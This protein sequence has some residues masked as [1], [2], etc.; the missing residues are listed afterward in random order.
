MKHRRRKLFSIPY[1]ALLSLSIIF[2][3]VFNSSLTGEFSIMSQGTI[4]YGWLRAEGK[5]LVDDEGHIVIL[6]GANFMGYG[7]GNWKRHTLEDYERMKSWGFN[8][9]R[10]P[11]GW[12]YMEPKPGF[13]NESYFA[14]I[15][16]DIT[17]AKQ[18]GLYVVINVAHLRWSPYFTFAGGK[19]NGLPIWMVNG[20]PDSLDGM[21]EA[22]TDFWLGKASNG[23]EPTTDNPSMQDRFVAMWK[24]LAARYRNETTIAAYDLF[25]EPLRG[26]LSDREAAKYIYPFYEKV[27]SG[28][29]QVDKNH[30]I[31]YQPSPGGYGIRY[32]RL[33]N[34]SNVMF[35]FHFYYFDG[36][37][38]KVNPPYSGNYE[39]LE[40]TF[41]TMRWELPLGNPIS[42]WNIP[43][44][45]GGFGSG[46]ETWARDTVKIFGKYELGWAWWAYYRSD[47]NPRALLYLNGSERLYLTQY[48][49]QT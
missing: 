34:Q 41:L 7:M 38:D 33:L 12:N 45:V 21:K 27:I 31:I 39:E 20:Y 3:G 29:R 42:N 24:Y 25:D 35:D 46:I 37:T 40:D 1:V 2:I 11:I 4:R 48:L 44:W 16:R 30:I 18:A 8:V 47:N 6:R 9:V 49:K 19:R 36:I 22:I 15:E 28:I 13:Y 10:L 17:W 32:A 23:S 14:I 26:T 5:W 43:I